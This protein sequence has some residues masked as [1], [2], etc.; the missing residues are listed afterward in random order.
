[1]TLGGVS[2]IQADAGAAF[3]GGFMFGFVGGMVFSAI[4]LSNYSNSNLQSYYQRKVVYINSIFDKSYNHINEPIKKLPFDEL[5]Y[6]VE[7]RINDIST[8]FKFKNN[9]Y[10]S[11]YENR[12]GALLF[13]EFKN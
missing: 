11:T 8:V 4:S 2:E 1:M 6:F 7:G 12:D 9:L 13:Y 5:R 3:V 10:F